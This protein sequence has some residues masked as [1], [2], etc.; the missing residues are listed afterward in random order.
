MARI[1]FLVTTIIN[2]NQKPKSQ[3]EDTENLNPPLILA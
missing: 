2:I 1:K 3:Q